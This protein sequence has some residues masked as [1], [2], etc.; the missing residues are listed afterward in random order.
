M[1]DNP[2]DLLNRHIKVSPETFLKLSLYHDLLLKWQSKINLVGAD[3]LADA[4]D[5]H[6]LDSLQLLN[7]IDDLSG[8]IVDVGSGAGFPGMTLAIGGATDMH[9][10]ESDGKK[11]TFLREIARLT[12]TKVS[13]H[14]CRAEDCEKLSADIIVSRAVSSIDNLLSFSLPQISHG[15][16][17]LFHKGKNYA[18][19]I[20]EAKE[21]WLF[22][23]TVI[24]SVTHDQSAILKL[25]HIRKRGYDS[26]R[27]GQKP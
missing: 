20:E 18:K 10:I 6:F 11:I 22:E 5:R 16:T 24:P 2:F 21:H 7:A 9:L 27:N 1:R 13:I 4:W 8:T 15:T 14:H 3:T 26:Q 17:C 23:I 12:E 19:E 25:T